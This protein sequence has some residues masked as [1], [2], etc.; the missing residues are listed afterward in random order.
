MSRPA[1]PIIDL[2]SSHTLLAAFGIDGRNPEYQRWRRDDGFRL[3]DLEDVLVSEGTGVLVVDWRGELDEAIDDVAEMLAPHGIE[4]E[5]SMDEYEPLGTVTIGGASAAIKYVPNDD[6]DF[7]DVILSLNRLLAGRAEF[8][9]WRSCE[10]SDTYA[11]ALLAPHA[12]S[13]LSTAVPTLIA[14]L[15]APLAPDAAGP[16]P[17]APWWR[18]LLRRS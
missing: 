3:D 18:R 15:F 2:A 1:S 10:G 13:E 16:A 5:A 11:Y 8:R 17:R 4:L 9:K 14:R 7:D 12:W 6:D